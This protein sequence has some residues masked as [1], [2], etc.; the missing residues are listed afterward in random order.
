MRTLLCPRTLRK[1]DGTHRRD[2]AKMPMMS[3]MAARLKRAGRWSRYRLRKQV[4][5]PVFGLMNRPEA[6]AN[7]C[8]AG[9]IRSEASGP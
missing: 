8:C 1:Q 3:A 5:E 7:S 6:S 4:V 9:S 2:T